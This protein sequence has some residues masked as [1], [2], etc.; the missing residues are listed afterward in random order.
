MNVG[1]FAKLNVVVDF[2]TIGLVPTVSTTLLTSPTWTQCWIDGSPGETG[3]ADTPT[4]SH[5]PQLAPGPAFP[6][7]SAPATIVTAIIPTAGSPGKE[8][9]SADAASGSST[10]KYPIANSS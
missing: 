9:V 8:T 6:E 2:K 7:P 1:A 5:P 3:S 10:F 4:T